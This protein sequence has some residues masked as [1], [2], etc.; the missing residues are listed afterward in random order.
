LDAP[1]ELLRD[2]A[3][4]NIVSV[5]SETVLVSEQDRCMVCTKC[6]P[7]ELLGDVA[8]ESFWTLPKVLPGDEAQVEAHFS[9]FG[10]SANLDARLVHFYAKRTIG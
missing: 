2:V 5:Y 4:G 8:H 3:Q 10:D 9:P 1:D 6:T 7:D